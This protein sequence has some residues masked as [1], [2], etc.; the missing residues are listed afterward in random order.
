[1]VNKKRIWQSVLVFIGF[2]F[3]VFMMNLTTQSLNY[4]I[5]WCFHISQKIAN[6]FELYSEIGTVVTPIY[7]WIG[8]LFVKIF[9]NS[10]ISMD[11]YSGVVAGAISTIIFNI[12]Q[13]TRKKENKYTHILFFFFMIVAL[14]KLALTNYNSCAMMWV[15]LAAF[16]E[17]RKERKIELNMP[18]FTKKK[19]NIYNLFIGIVL[20]LAFFTKQNIGTY[21]VLATGIFSLV[22]KC[23]IKK[24]NTFKEIFLKASGFLMVLFG[25]LAYFALSGTFADF[26]N[27]CL[28]GLLEFGDK[29]LRC[30]F[31]MPYFGIVIIL[32]LSFMLMKEKK[33]NATV[34][35]AEII[36]L[37][38]LMLLVYPLT[39][40]YHVFCSML[41]LLPVVILLLNEVTE[42]ESMLTILS[43]AFLAFTLYSTKATGGE[44]TETEVMF[45]GDLTILSYYLGVFLV[46]FFIGMAF[47]TIKN[48]INIVNNILI[49]S[50][51]GFVVVSVL[52]FRTNISENSYLPEGL[53]IYKNHGYSEE[54][55]DYI[56]SVIQYVLQK[57][58][59][60]ENVYI[61]SADASYYMA[62]LG[63]NQYKYDLNLYGSLGYNGEQVLIE[64]TKV[65]G[66]VIILKDKNLMFQEPE[67][68]DEFIKENYEVIDEVGN[69]LV[70]TTKK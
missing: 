4:D 25:F 48:N 35:I 57:E 9:G 31:P 20:G 52:Q 21:G 43:V 61:V 53:E 45:S 23:F 70:Y 29:N 58:A 14:T 42:T 51:L 3:F 32:T 69:L 30:G 17:V 15:L 56:D 38:C 49:A 68:F 19:E 66:D 33:K 46:A 1:M 54:V 10:M 39:N 16:L 12:I 13:E 34:W 60:G 62:A 64:E 11:L 50:S 44:L 27:F 8:S 67:A 22:Y 55:L 47:A 26:I 40:L 18:S 63:R 28:G 59:E 37:L 41:M 2:T 36:Y 5:I 24:E 6:G 65:L 7:F